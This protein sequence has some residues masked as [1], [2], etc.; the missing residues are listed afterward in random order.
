VKAIGGGDTA[1][2]GRWRRTLLNLTD[3]A[4]CVYRPLMLLGSVGGPGAGCRGAGVGRVATRCRS[5][6][7]LRHGRAGQAQLSGSGQNV[8]ALKSEPAKLSDRAR[9]ADLNPAFSARLSVHVSNKKVVR[10]HL[11]HRRPWVQPRS[12]RRRTTTWQPLRGLAS[13]ADSAAETRSHQRSSGL[14]TPGGGSGPC[15][16]RTVDAPANARSAST[17]DASR[18]MSRDT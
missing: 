8:T 17:A 15:R 10:P 12:I 16:S 9:R 7:H 18:A 13:L 2:T 1:R 6:A 11:I 4:S 5:A 3:V 14:L